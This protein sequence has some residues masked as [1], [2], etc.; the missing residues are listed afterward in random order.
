MNVNLSRISCTKKIGLLSVLGLFLLGGSI[1]T[2]LFFLL[3]DE[4]GLQAK[5]RQSVNMAIA[6]ELLH[7]Y[8]R[9]FSIHDNMLFI[10]D[11]P[12]N[13]DNQIVDKVKDLVGGTAT[14]FMG[15]VRVATN[16]IGPD[17]KRAAGTKLAPGPVYNA[18]IKD[19][20]SFRGEADILGETY[21]TAYDPIKSSSGDVI[22]ILYVGLKKQDFFGIVDTMIT[23]ASWAVS[24]MVLLISSTIVYFVRRQLLQLLQLEATMSRLQQED[25]SVIVPA[26]ERGDEIGRMAKAVQRFKEFII[27]KKD[28]MSRKNYRKMKSK[29]GMP[30]CCKQLMNSRRQLMVLLTLWRQRL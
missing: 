25:I 28:C 23:H 20:Q 11:H 10:G 13:G 1:V 4:M 15:D 24:V 6:W 18:V 8:G 22:G 19:G 9:D 14:I 21:F 2:I 27:E 12:L 7:D 3:R 26:Q 5:T 16:V 30:K 17:G 29:N